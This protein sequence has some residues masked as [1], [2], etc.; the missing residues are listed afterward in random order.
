MYM[1]VSSHVVLLERTVMTHL[2]HAI[3]LLNITV[4]GCRVLLKHN[5]NNNN[6]NMYYESARLHVSTLNSPSLVQAKLT[7][8][9]TA[10]YTATNISPA[11]LT[12]VS[13]FVG[14]VPHVDSD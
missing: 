9:Q 1:E 8:T 12:A 7:H 13:E 11:L 14:G 6:N 10:A 2:T 3:L 5:N 4:T